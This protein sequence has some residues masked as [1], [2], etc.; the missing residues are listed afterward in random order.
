MNDR[1]TTGFQAIQ[2]VLHALQGRAVALSRVLLLR[3]FFHA[4]ERPLD[5]PLVFVWQCRDEHQHQ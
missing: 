1:L 3:R 2:V 4:F 5:C